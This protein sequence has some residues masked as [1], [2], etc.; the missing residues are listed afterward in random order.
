MAITLPT[1]NEFNV[2]VYSTDIK[3]VKTLKKVCQMLQ[4]PLVEAD[5]AADLLDY[6]YRIGFIDKALF[7]ETLQQW[8]NEVY[9]GKKARE[10]ELVVL[11]GRPVSVPMPLSL[12]CKS[13]SVYT[14]DDFVK[15]INNHLSLV[16]IHKERNIKTRVHRIV[17]LIDLIN[18]NYGLDKKAVCKEFGI[19][20]RTLFRDLKLIKEVFP[21]TYYF[22]D[23]GK[24]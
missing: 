8:L 16:R 24:D 13:L 19:T 22:F 11:G 4:L 9:K 21:D 2:L 15:I 10:W 7:N 23:D 1:E 14:V 20:E 12:F 3:I 18:E 6:T 5:K 17:A